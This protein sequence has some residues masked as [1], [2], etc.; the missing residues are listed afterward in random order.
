LPKEVA[1]KT[2]SEATG[3]ETKKIAKNQNQ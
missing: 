2:V 3:A 1:K